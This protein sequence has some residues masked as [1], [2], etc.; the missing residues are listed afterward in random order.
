MSQK[1][2]SSREQ[3]NLIWRKITWCHTTPNNRNM[4]GSHLT[5]T[6][7]QKLNYKRIDRGVDDFIEQVLSGQNLS[8]AKRDMK[9]PTSNLF[10][11]SLST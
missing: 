1:V 9:K 3:V 8:S 2:V 5:N 10:I 11:S 6:K 7:K 4:S